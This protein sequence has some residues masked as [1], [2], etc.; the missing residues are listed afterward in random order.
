MKTYICYRE[1][2]YGPNFYENTEYE[3]DES[4]YKYFS[5]YDEQLKEIIYPETCREQI[6]FKLSDTLLWHNRKYNIKNHFY[7]SY[8]SVPK[9]TKFKSTINILNE[10]EEKWQFKKTKKYNLYQKSKKERGKAIPNAALLKVDKKWLHPVMLSLYMLIVRTLSS[11]DISETTT[12][13]KDFIQ[14]LYKLGHEQTNLKSIKLIKLMLETHP[15]I[16]FRINDNYK[17][18]YDS[19]DKTLGIKMITMDSYKQIYKYQHVYQYFRRKSINNL[20][21]LWKRY[22]A[23]CNKIAYKKKTS[24]LKINKLHKIINNKK[25]VLRKSKVAR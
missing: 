17:K 8:V 4:E 20:L 14:K 19:Y 15:R 23:F 5:I 2:D 3:Y 6:V 25:A 7:L 1:Y 24:K 12:N 13:L 11:K 16:F 10:I 21:K 18:L 22:L 9:N